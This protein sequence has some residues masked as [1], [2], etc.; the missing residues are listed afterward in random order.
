MDQQFQQRF[1]SLAD[2]QTVQMDIM[3]TVVI[4]CLTWSLSSAL[5]EKG[6]LEFDEGVK[7]TSLEI[8]S[9]KLVSRCMQYANELERVV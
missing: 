1:D 9:H 2:E 8:P 3:E 6:R 4:Q 7:K 5:D